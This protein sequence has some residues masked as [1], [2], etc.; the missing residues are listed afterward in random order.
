M[1]NE[2]KS[3]NTITAGRSRTFKIDDVYEK[4]ELHYN[5]SVDK[6]ATQE[7]FIY[8]QDA[9]EVAL[10]SHIVKVLGEKYGIIPKE[11]VKK[12]V[13]EEPKVKPPE[14]KPSNECEFVDENDR[15]CGKTLTA[16]EREWSEKNFPGHSYCYKHQKLLKDKKQEI[17]GWYS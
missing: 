3:E 16:S 10:D 8:V 13:K 17:T 15:V 14:G 6:S 1:T 9:V 7:D 2:P 12:E 11:I 5:H 4:F